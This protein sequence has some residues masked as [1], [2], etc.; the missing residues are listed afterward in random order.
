MS[1]PDPKQAGFTLLEV[2]I[3]VAVIGTL[4]AMAAPSIVSS[5]R[6]QRQA[7]AGQD[8]VRFLRGVRD[9]TRR[10]GVAHN[11]RWMAAG[12][13][14]GV[15]AVWMGANNRCRLTDWNF[16]FSNHT[17]VTTFDMGR[18]NPL[19]EGVPATPGGGHEVLVLRTNTVEFTTVTGVRTVGSGP[20]VDGVGPSASSDLDT[21]E[22]C[23]EPSG[24]TFLRTPAALGNTT[25]TL[26]MEPQFAL[27]QFSVRRIA[28]NSSTTRVGVD[29]HVILS[30]NGVARAR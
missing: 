30:P 17:P 15:L 3:V 24:D 6:Q 18:Y 14:L 13:D 11:M 8:L 2:V 16:A 5:V 23:F 7:S 25:P 4:A 27:V 12:D 26:T 21:G 22:L 28:A 19:G 1:R 29:R 20:T 9:L 10:S